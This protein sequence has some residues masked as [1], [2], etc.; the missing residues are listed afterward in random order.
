MLTLNE[1]LFMACLVVALPSYL[2]SMGSR[3]LA[4]HLLDAEYHLLDQASRQ[5]EI[6]T[7]H[8]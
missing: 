2:V 3:A 4:L 1:Y 8:S 7:F 5:L 6:F